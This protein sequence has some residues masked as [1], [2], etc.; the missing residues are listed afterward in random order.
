MYLSFF[1]K[2]MSRQDALHPDRVVIGTSDALA[3]SVLHDIFSNLKPVGQIDIMLTSP[4]ESEMIKLVSNAYLS[5][6]ISFWNEVKW[7]CRKFGLNP[8]SI[9]LGVGKDS[10]VSSYGHGKFGKFGGFCLPKDL[11][12]LRIVAKT[13]GCKTRIL[14]ATHL[15]NQDEPEDATS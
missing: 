14:D 7:I 8:S 4:K 12:T 6:Q 5:T 9:A 3:F 10:R 2:G 1:V 11:N 15:V 13:E